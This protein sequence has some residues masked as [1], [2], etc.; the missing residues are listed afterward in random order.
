MT[1]SK[2]DTQQ[3]NSLPCAECRSAECGILF[4]IM[5]S[6]IMLYVII[7]T[8]IILSVV[9]LNVVMLYVV[10]MPLALEN[11]PKIILFLYVSIRLWCAYWRL[12]LFQTEQLK[13]SKVFKSTNVF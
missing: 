9:I 11:I 2:S 10:A 13:K 4:T 12:G 6:V 8:V 5:L 3:N 7:L 1:L